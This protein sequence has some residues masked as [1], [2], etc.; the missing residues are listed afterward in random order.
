MALTHVV[1]KNAKARE[2]AYKLSDERGLYLLIRPNGGKYWRWKYRVGGKEKVLALGVYPEITLSDARKLCDQARRQHHSGIDPMA[3]RKR[4]KLLAQVRAE[5]SFE[6]IT[7]EWHHQQSG[8]WTE[9][10]AHRVISSLEKDIF[11]EFGRRPITEIEPAE[12]LALLR[13]IEERDALDLPGRLLQRC[14]AVFTYAIQTSRASFNPAAELSGA[15]KTRKVVHRPALA[16]G[17]LPEFLVKLDHYDGE[18]ITRYALTLL[19]LTFLRPGELRGARWAEL[20]REHSLWRIPGDR[21]K[22]KAPH[23][24]PLSRQALKLIDELRT[25]TERY[26][27]LFP[28]RNRPRHPISENT[29][30]YALYRMGYRSQ[31]T[32]HGFRATA[33]TILNE[34]GFT[35]DAIE[36]QLAHAERNQVRAAYHRTEY[37]SERRKMMQWWGD[38]IET[39]RAKGYA[40]NVIDLKRRKD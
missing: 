23:L 26:D 21:M 30:T 20:D 32:A 22:M 4:D 38:F 36:R 31:A 1:I 29:M 39:E 24:V 19:V 34:H 5:N 40:D 13:K 14:K 12:L 33:S 9:K 25:L 17:D 35:P 28:N 8:V 15:L 18:P 16:R 37:L 3:V 27:L 7:R 10:H 2:K 11:P 6:A